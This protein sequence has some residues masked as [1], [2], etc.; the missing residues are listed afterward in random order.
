MLESGCSA[1]FCILCRFKG[2]L[3]N[4][5][6]LPKSDLV[7]WKIHLADAPGH[8][9]SDVTWGHWVI[10]VCQHQTPSPWRPNQGWSDPGS[11]LLIHG[12]LVAFSVASVAAL[13]FFLCLPGEAQR[14]KC[15]AEWLPCKSS[16]THFQRFTASSPALPP[17]AV[18]QLLVLGALSLVNLIHS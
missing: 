18:Y 4:K 11:A 9:I 13:V 16:A 15:S 12:Q 2:A 8:I 1:Y 7:R 3:T 14:C 6:Q 10:W 17:A 5:I